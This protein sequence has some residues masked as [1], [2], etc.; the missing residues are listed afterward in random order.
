M[1]VVLTAIISALTSLL[2]VVVTYVLTGRRETRLK[3]A[4]ERERV[5]L[6]YLNPLRLYLVE[7]HFRLSE[8]RRRVDNEGGKCEAL[9]YVLDPKEVSEQSAEWFNGHG[10]YLISSCYLC[11]CLFYHLKKVRE[12]LPYIRLGHS[13]DTKL[14]A[15]MT[16]ISIAFLRNLG[17]FYATQPSLGTDVYLSTEGRLMSY[18][19]FCE[20]LQNPDR[21]VWFDRLLTLYVEI[22]EGKRQEQ[23]AEAVS[24]LEVLSGFLDKAV[25][26]GESI[27][28]RMEAE[29]ITSI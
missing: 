14:L 13:D 11:A 4:Q 28:E 7:N 12:D 9:L 24:A 29:G 17:V 8:I 15:M 18:R 25:G 5:K 21:R 27:K 26:G 6:E 23:V 22:G 19:E 1:E 20:A 3:Q 10:C 2:V 16:K